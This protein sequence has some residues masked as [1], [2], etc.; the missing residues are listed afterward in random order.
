VQIATKYAS[1]IRS[2]RSVHSA[3]AMLFAAAALFGCGDRADSVAPLAASAIVITAPDGAIPVTGTMQF[4]ATV[5][6][7]DGNTLTTI[8]TYTVANGGGTITGGGLFTA[9]DSVGTFVNTIVATIGTVTATSTITVSAGALASITVAPDTVTVA[10]GATQ[11]FVAVGKD[12]HGNVVAILDRVWSATAGGTIDTSGTFTAG[13]TAG[14]FAGAIHVTSGSV[15]AT[16]S[17]TVS[18]G[19]LASVQVHPFTVNLPQGWVQ[20]F[21]VSGADAYGNIVA[22]PNRVWSVGLGGTIDSTGLFTAGTTAG[23]FTNTVTATSGTLS[24]SSTV[25]V[26]PGPLARIVVTPPMVL[27]VPNGTLQYS[28]VGYDA[29]GNTVAITPTWSVAAASAALG[30]ISSSGL[31]SVSSAARGTFNNAVVAS[32]GSVSGTGSVTIFL[33]CFPICGGGIP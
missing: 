18:A 5:T 21:T 17:V 9:G 24:G 31:L 28:A 10:V 6:D 19:P 3:I 30:T 33:P 32:S 22:V 26:Q 23:T 16:S 13:T 2:H 27:I 14:A 15:T 7:V 4:V 12:A 20:Q 29:G 1:A 25:T 11:H 8:P